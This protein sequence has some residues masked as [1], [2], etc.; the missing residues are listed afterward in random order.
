MFTNNEPCLLL[1]R[2]VCSIGPGTFAREMALYYPDRRHTDAH[3]FRI[4]V[5]RLRKALSV[6]L[7]TAALANTLPSLLMIIERGG[8][9][10]DNISVL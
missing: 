1:S 2:G 4:L 10:H 9:C 6:G 7:T 5:Q 3:V 8:D